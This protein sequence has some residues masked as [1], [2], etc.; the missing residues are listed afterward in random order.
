MKFKYIWTPLN[1]GLKG[2]P[3]PYSNVM[4][5]SRERVEK[6]GKKISNKVPIPWQSLSRFNL[7]RSLGVIQ[8]HEQ[9]VITQGL[10]A[11]C[12]LGF[13]NE[14]TAIIWVVYPNKDTFKV[15]GRVFSDHFPF[16]IECMKETRLFCP[17]MKITKDNEF[18]K[19]PYPELLKIAQEY[20]AV[21]STQL[22]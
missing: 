22:T 1:Q 13:L 4:K 17:H 5:V 3:R 11:Y 12:G 20:Y 21:T 10:C 14:E 19:G 2:L 9:E 7:G 6:A 16:H 15:G 18:I 8:E